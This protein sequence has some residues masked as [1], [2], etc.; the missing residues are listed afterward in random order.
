MALNIPTHRNWLKNRIQRCKQ[1]QLKA[2]EEIN[3][4]V[5]RERNGKEIIL[6]DGTKLT[7]FMS[8]S[9]LGLDQDER[10][11]VAAS[12][13]IK[14]CGVN[15]AVARTRMR[16][17]ASV[18]LEDLLNKIFKGYCV[19]FTSLHV[20][21]Q[22]MFPLIASGEMPSYP[23]QDNGI[24]FILDKKAHASIQMQRALMQQFGE[25]YLTNFSCL[26]EIE[27]NFEAAYASKLTPLAIADGVCSMGGLTPIKELFD[28]AEK[29]QGYIYL[30]DAH[31]ISIHG[32]NGCG[33][34]LNEL[35]HFHPR[36]ILAVSL[37]KGFGANG[38][39][40]VL[41]SKVDED[42]VR[43]FASPYMFSNPLP[44]AI[45]DSAIA[46]AKIHLSSEI[47]TL[48]KALQKRLEYFDTLSQNTALSNSI[49]NLKSSFPIRGVKIGNEFKDIEVTRQLRK[50]GLA[51][52][53]AM[54]PT[55]PEGESILRISLGADHRLEDIKKLHACLARMLT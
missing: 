13:S 35:K 41:K 27:K 24:V 43:C 21:H 55:V 2:A 42:I 46:S 17:A 34:V 20:S 53:A 4:V 16:V 11:I 49:I 9:Y 44:L 15:F 47:Y 30:D 31:G 48:Q 10:L 14:K 54:Y 39:A 50:E 1:Y 12:E 25:V 19:T 52:T 6:E 18:E 33:Y 22:G 26:S 23:I 5:V 29:Y 45:V 36:L 8:C 7:E 32:E 38:A 3:N 40:I 37:S 51:V 28:F